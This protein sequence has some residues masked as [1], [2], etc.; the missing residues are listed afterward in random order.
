MAKGVCW[1]PRGKK[2][3]RG[4]TK[5]K[6]SKRWDLPGLAMGLPNREKPVKKYYCIKGEVGGEKHGIGS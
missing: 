1:T 6:M 4:M 5:G 3:G 2:S